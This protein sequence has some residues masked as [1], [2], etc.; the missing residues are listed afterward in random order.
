MR[1]GDER[2]IF[3]HREDDG[4]YSKIATIWYGANRIREVVVYESGVTKEE[5]FRRKLANKL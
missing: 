5:F 4:T 2:R 3:W 1:L